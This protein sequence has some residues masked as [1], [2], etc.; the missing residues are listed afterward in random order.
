MDLRNSGSDP[1][2]A[3]P[4]TTP[5]IKFAIDGLIGGGGERQAREESGT[6]SGSEA[7]RDMSPLAKR[8]RT[9]T[10]TTDSNRSTVEGANEEV[11]VTDDDAQSREKED[12]LKADSGQGTDPSLGP[13]PLSALANS[14]NHLAAAAAAAAA[15]VS[16]FNHSQNLSPF[17]QNAALGKLFA[18]K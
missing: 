18:G 6:G 1:P 15:A 2:A 16:S 14:G 10:S 9:S 7:D 11:Y 3:T 13:S 12:E 5:V 4:S 8:R 17:V